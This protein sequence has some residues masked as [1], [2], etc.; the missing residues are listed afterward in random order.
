[1]FE[2]IANPSKSKITIQYY[3][4]LFW[5]DQGLGIVYFGDTMP[6]V[7]HTMGVV[8]SRLDYVFELLDQAFPDANNVRDVVGLFRVLNHLDE[9]PETYAEGNKVLG[10]DGTIYDEESLTD[11]WNEDDY[12]DSEN[13]FEG[14]EDDFDTGF[15][16]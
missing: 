4:G 16:D 8:Q 2:S 1:M 7:V 5:A 10:A 6:R 11:I 13:C 9:S 3:Y 12:D 15:E 14:S